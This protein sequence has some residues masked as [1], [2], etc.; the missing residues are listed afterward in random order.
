[1]PVRDSDLGPRSTNFDSSLCPS[2]GDALESSHIWVC[3]PLVGVTG[4]IFFWIVWTIWTSRNQRLFE[5][6]HSSPEEVITKACDNARERL[7]AQSDPKT[8]VTTPMTSPQQPI[9]LTPHGTVLCNSDAAWNQITK[10][11]GLGWIF[12]VQGSRAQQGFQ[13]HLHVRSALQAE[14]MAIRAALTHAIHLGYTKIWLRSDSLGL[15]KA[16]A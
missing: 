8:S 3:L 2:F 15:I 6:H 7:L 11:S 14:A 9:P 1:M 16:I 12:M 5:Y 10:A 4:G 13:S